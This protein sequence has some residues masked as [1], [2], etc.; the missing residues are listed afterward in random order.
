MKE[1]QCSHM[2]KMRVGEDDV[3]GFPLQVGFD[4][5]CIVTRIYDGKK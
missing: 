2:V 1:R 3:C 5:I 4:A